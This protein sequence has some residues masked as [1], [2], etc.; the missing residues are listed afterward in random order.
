VA[1]FDRP[2]LASFLEGRLGVIDLGHPTVPLNDALVLLVDD[3]R[4]GFRLSKTMQ[5]IYP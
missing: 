5:N 2:L 4:L 1:I 3:F